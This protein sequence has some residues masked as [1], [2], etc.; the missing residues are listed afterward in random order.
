VRRP[1]NVPTE[2]GRPAPTTGDP[3]LA[4]VPT[5]SGYHRWSRGRDN[6]EPADPAELVGVPGGHAHPMADR[7]GGDPEIVGTDH[8]TSLH[9]VGPDLCMDPRYRLGDGDGLEPAEEM[10][11]EGTPLR[12][13]CSP[14]PENTVEQLA[15]GDDADAA[16]L[17]AEE[18]VDL[19]STDPTFEIDQKVG[20]DQEGHGSPGGPVAFRRERI[21]AASSGSGRGPW[22]TSSRNRSAERRRPRGGPITAT[23]APFRVISISSPAATRVRMSEKLRAASVAVILDMRGGYQIYQMEPRS[24]AERARNAE[25]TPPVL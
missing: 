4:E 3:T 12:P 13:A 2:S 5:S 25:G 9:E 8:L 1:E 10:L 17:V 7:R 20:V 14:R 6:A 19:G 11:H 21:S 15:H 22:T 23:G 24:A 18:L 16:F